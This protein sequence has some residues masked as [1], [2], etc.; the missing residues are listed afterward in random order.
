[1]KEVG[2]FKL[3]YRAFISLTQLPE[4][5]KAAIQERL[6]PLANLPPQ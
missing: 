2:R 4:A 5:D 1:M 6:A 3:H